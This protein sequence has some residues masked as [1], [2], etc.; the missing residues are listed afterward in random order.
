MPPPSQPNILV[1]LSDDHAQWAS[2]AYGNSEIRSPNI[3]YLAET[4][5]TMQ[6]GY[7]PCPVCS[8][9]RA[10]FFTGRRPSQHGIHDFI[11]T[12]S[13]EF[14]HGWMKDEVTLPQ[15]LSEGGYETA[16]IGK[17]HCTVDSVPPQPGF[18]RWVSYDS[19][20]VGW[21]NQYLH[22]G[23]VHFSDQGEMVVVD[24]F[25][26]RYLGRQAVNFLRSRNRARPFFLFFAPVDTHAP[27][28]GHPSRFADRYRDAHFWDIP[29]KEN[30]HY[31]STPE[32]WSF[33]GDGTS[34][35]D[36]ALAQYYSAVSMIGDQVGLLLDELDGSGELENTLLVY[37]ANHGYMTG[38]HGLWGKGPSSRPQNFYEEAIRVPYFLRWEDRLPARQSPSVPFDHCDMFVTI[39]NAARIR[40]PDDL[41]IRINSPGRSLLRF[42]GDP[43]TGW[44][45]HQYCE[46]GPAS[47]ISDGRRKLIRRY[48]PHRGRYS[49]EFYDLPRDPRESRNRIDEGASQDDISAL[50]SVFED[51]FSRFE[52][53]LKSVRNLL[54]QPPCNASGRWWP[55]P[56]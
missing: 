52:D 43:D 50:S 6:N 5:L 21:Q 20:T 29:E 44:R 39:L 46:Y 36:E 15:L 23:P 38:H 53:P 18:D 22:R 45:H 49:D 11:A 33:R 30:S 32:R 17:W 13:H 35:R 7:T 3:D 24:D 10:S 28:E 25:Q 16:L 4:G 41:R 31:E 19:R 56:Q 47:M 42:L 14:E 37:T 12:G 8:P 1:I 55:S 51:Q 48:P 2:H 27:Q 54:N 9:A 34:T 40:L 26:S